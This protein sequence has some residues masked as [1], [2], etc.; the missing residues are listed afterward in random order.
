[1]KIHYMSDLHLEIAASNFELPKGDVLVLAGD[2]F[3]VN[4][5]EVNEHGEFIDTLAQPALEFLHQAS[6]N[7]NHV[8]YCDGNHTFYGSNISDEHLVTEVLPSNFTHLHDSHKIIDGVV[9][10]GGV[11]WTDFAN[12][13][14]SVMANIQYAMNDFRRVRIND[15]D[16]A[17]KF[18]PSDA[19][20]RHLI[21]RDYLEDIVK[22]HKNKPIV[23]VTHHCPSYLCVADE[24]VN[25]SISDGYCTNMHSFIEDSD[26]IVAWVCGHT[27]A[28]KHFEI[29][30][31]DIYMNCRGYHGY[32]YS[33]SKFEPDT[34]FE[35]ES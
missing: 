9:F 14:P 19:R 26:N 20:T 17:R 7:F 30:N 25:S 12:G 27:H 22:K 28:T 32:E 2:I 33:A 11:L 16:R 4:Q 29:G 13:N 3:T 23:I 6:D 21:T 8:L 1:M 18:R 10:A 31:T 24:H 34:Y 5:F 15:T 35:I